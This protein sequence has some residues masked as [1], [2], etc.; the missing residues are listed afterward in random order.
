MRL[1]PVPLR[2][3]KARAR[4]GD[5]LAEVASESLGRSNPALS[6]RSASS[7]V[8]R[9]TLVVAGLVTVVL[10]VAVPVPTAAALVALVTTL[11]AAVLWHRMSLFAGSMRHVDMERVTDAEARGFP[12]RNLPVYTVL[13]PVY[14]EPTMV[15]RVLQEI[16]RIDYPRNRLE[17]LLLVEDDDEETFEALVELDLPTYVVPVG[18]AVREPRTKPKACNV[19]LLMA[20]GSLVTIY[21]AEDRPDPLQLRRAAVAFSR[22]PMNVACLQARLAYHNVSQ[23]LL[24]RW[25]TNEYDVWFRFWLPGLVRAGQPIPLGGTSNH[26]RR[27]LLLAVGGWDPYNVTE[28]ADLGVRLARCG[29]EVAVLGSTTLEEANSDF[30]NWV[31]QRSRWYKGYFQTV[32]VHTRAPRRL[33][34][35]LGLRQTI[36]FLLFVGGT[37]LLAMLN[38]VFWGLTLLWWLDRPAFVAALFPPLLYYIGMT[39]WILGGLGLVYSGVASARASGKPQLVLS[40]IAVPLYWGM[41]ALAAVKA[42]VQLIFQPS[43]WEKTTHGLSGNAAAGGWTA[44]HPTP[45]RNSAA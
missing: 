31:K 33:L 7:R 39:C 1:E 15:G 28:D 22:L 41:M 21:D 26:I 11:H 3:S 42:F 27:D 24:T 9:I 5:V 44:V 12:R 8:Q 20:R 29:F 36:A 13:V 4:P 32:L 25:F 43:Y 19:G 37:P 18:V 14:R 10:L 6:A 35:E 23:N 38:P 2:L 30:V 16:D 45:A 40:G 34:N 17:V